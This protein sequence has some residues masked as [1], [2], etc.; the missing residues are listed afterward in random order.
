MIE[1]AVANAGSTAQEVFSGTVLPFGPVY[2][3]T[4]DGGEGFLLWRDYE[5]GCITIDDGGPV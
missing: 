4:V 1:L 2:A 3:E 5:E